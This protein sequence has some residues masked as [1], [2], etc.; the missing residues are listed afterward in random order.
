MSIFTMCEENSYIQG[1]VVVL[2]RMRT[3][4]CGIKSED[5]K[6]GTERNE[7]L[8][9]F[10]VASAKIPILGQGIKT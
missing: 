4:S 9:N 5:T 10:P 1:A 7:T 6:P 3:G 2:L 8:R